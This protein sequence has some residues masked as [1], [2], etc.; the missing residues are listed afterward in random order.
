LAVET[1]SIEFVNMGSEQCEEFRCLRQFVGAL[2][3]ASVK[4]HEAGHVE[5]GTAETISV[6]PHHRLRQTLEADGQPERSAQ[7]VPGNRHLG[8]DG[9]EHAETVS[10]GEDLV[11]DVRFG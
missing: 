5:I 7:H 4:I 8:Y 11:V 6:T 3:P 1:A 9:T 10:R 2:A